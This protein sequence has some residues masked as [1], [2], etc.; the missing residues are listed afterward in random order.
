MAKYDIT[1]LYY[2]VLL[3]YNKQPLYK[4]MVIVLTIF[5]LWHDN[6]QG[7]NNC[8]SISV[9]PGEATGSLETTPI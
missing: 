1:I 6:A 4:Q 7:N 2:K 5:T 3:I 8:I 9:C